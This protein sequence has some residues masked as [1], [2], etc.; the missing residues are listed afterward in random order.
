VAAGAWVTGRVREMN[1]FVGEIPS[2]SAPVP[3]IRN[4]RFGEKLIKVN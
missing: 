3:E 1:K 4:D 2:V